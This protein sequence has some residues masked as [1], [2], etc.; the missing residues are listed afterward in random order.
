MTHYT[1]QFNGAIPQLATVWNKNVFKKLLKSGVEH[2]NLFCWQPVPCSGWQQKTPSRRIPDGSQERCN[3]HLK[4]RSWRDRGTSVTA[5]S[6]P[7]KMMALGEQSLC[8]QFIYL[9]IYYE[10]YRVHKHK[11]IENK[12]KIKSSLYNNTPVKINL[13]L[14]VQCHIGK[15]MLNV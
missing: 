12:N 14:T 2:I 4:S 1:L 8:A 5:V 10:S 7:V 6:M 13:V 3:C 15:V 9:F 11:N